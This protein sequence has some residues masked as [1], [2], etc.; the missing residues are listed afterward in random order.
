M[1]HEAMVQGVYDVVI[2][3]AGPAGLTAG[4]YTGRARLRTLLLEKETLG[5]QMMNMDL[6]EN[7][8]GFENG[9]IGPELASSVMGQVSSA[10]IKVEL[11]EVQGIEVGVEHRVIKTTMGDYLTKAV[12]IAGGACPTKLGVPGEEQLIGKGVFYCA[13]CEGAPFVDKVVAVAGGGDAGITEG[14][15]LTR[16]VSK[17]IVIET[18]PRLTASKVL[19]ERARLN[20]KIEIRC[21]TKI[22][23][24]SGDTMVKELSLVE[25]QTGTRSKLEVD[26]LLVHVGLEP[27]TTYL[28]GIVPLNREGQ[29]IVNE[30]LET[31]IRGIFAAGDIRHGSP[32]QIATAVG[33]GATA[34]LS[35]EKFLSQVA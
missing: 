32:R 10:G 29:I 15:Y 11:A 13:V 34:A 17:V 24:I 16:I 20:P 4:L 5:G 21:G 35:A 28:R 26:G 33:D 23:R 22:E 2:I 30:R 27:N 8:P 14:L 12:I 7:Y 1:G 18:M 6:V 19:Q 9:I 3:G 25:D 31:Q